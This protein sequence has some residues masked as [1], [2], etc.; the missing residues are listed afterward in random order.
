MAT[1][2]YVA[3][4]APQNGWPLSIGTTIIIISGFSAM[5]AWSVGAVYPGGARTPQG[6]AT[7]LYLYSLARSP[8]TD[9]NV[10]HGHAA[11]YYNYKDGHRVRETVVWATSK[12]N[13]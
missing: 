6:P 12:T 11:K 2:R 10:P 13:M 8:P 3:K 1:P 5:S 7:G 9:N 4:N